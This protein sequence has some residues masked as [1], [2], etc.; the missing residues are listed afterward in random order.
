MM[1]L[2]EFYSAIAD[3]YAVAK[4]ERSHYTKEEIAEKLNRQLKT[5]R[6]VGGATSPQTTGI[7]YNA[8]HPSYRGFGGESYE[9]TLVGV[10][11]DQ[12]IQAKDF[13]GALRQYQKETDTL[14]KSFIEIYN[15][16]ERIKALDDKMATLASSSNNADKNT[17]VLLEKQKAIEEAKLKT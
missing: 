5:G 9:K 2:E 6:I 3:A 14:V 13:R 17:L 16:K 12:D 4:G 11:D 8:R 15:R 7:D 1:S 10:L